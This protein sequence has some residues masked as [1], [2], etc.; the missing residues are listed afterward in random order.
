M[1]VTIDGTTGITTPG[2]INTGNLSVAGTT[3][4]TVPL[5]IA[6]GGTGATA[7]TANNVIIGNGASPVQFVAPGSSGNVL[8]SNGTTWASNTPATAGMVLINTQTAN[9]SSVIDFVFTGSYTSY[10][11][12][13]SNVLP[14][15]ANAQFYSRFSTDGGATFDATAGNYIWQWTSLVTNGTSTPGQGTLAGYTSQT[16]I[17]LIVSGTN[18]N[19]EGGV[20]FTATVYQPT[21]VS[22]TTMT[23]LGTSVTTGAVNLR[24]YQT[25]GT[26]I[27]STGAVNAIR[28]LPASGNFTS[29]IFKLYGIS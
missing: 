21:N 17:R 13:A 12:I 7:L 2:E 9:A 16:E 26:R 14:S 11:I 19:A 29:G 27:V 8:T 15:V 6:S 22:Y 23:F 5:P 20:N 28:F 18:T 24:Q 1:A 25:M 3:A 10:Q 4:L